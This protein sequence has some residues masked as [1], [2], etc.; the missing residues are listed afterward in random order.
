MLAE[1][2]LASFDVVILNAILSFLCNLRA[3]FARRKWLWGFAVAEAERVQC[4]LK[5][6]FWLE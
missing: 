1:R 6:A 5:C 2:T 3:S 4:Q